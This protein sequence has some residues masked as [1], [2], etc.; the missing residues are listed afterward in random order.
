MP[1]AAH[2]V[3]TFSGSGGNS[4]CEHSRRRGLRARISQLGRCM[5]SRCRRATTSG[6]RF[7]TQSSRDARCDWC[8][9]SEPLGHR[10]HM[11]VP[12]D[13]GSRASGRRRLA[14][15]RVTMTA[16]LPAIGRDRPSVKSRR[17]AELCR[18][19]PAQLANG[20]RQSHDHGARSTAARRRSSGQRGADAAP[21]ALAQPPRVSCT[22]SSH[23]R[24][25]ERPRES[26][27]PI[28]AP[29]RRRARGR[30]R[31]RCYLSQPRPKTSKQ[32]PGRQQRL[33]AR[34]QRAPHVEPAGRARVQRATLVPPAPTGR[35][36]CCLRQRPRP[37][38]R[39]RPARRLPRIQGPIARGGRARE[40]GR[41]PEAERLDDCRV[42]R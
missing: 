29:T 38:L 24:T 7:A 18:G 36:R 5:R 39:H 19:H 21:F 33:Q 42:G 37:D 20:R 11:I 30:L 9:D 16:P 13:R 1:A 35:L 34:S 23:S 10:S 40:S 8:R 28:R 6:A 15:R 22:R 32:K 27:A 12:R 26:R 4:R 25:Q 2:R 31:C 14:S 41:E 17:S 3:G